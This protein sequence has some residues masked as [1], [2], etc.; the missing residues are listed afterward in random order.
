[1]NVEVG[2]VIKIIDMKDE[3]NYKNKVGVVT[4]IDSLGQIHGTWGG[5]ALLKDDVFIIIDNQHNKT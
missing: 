1:M 2:M 4:Y 5:C 3:P